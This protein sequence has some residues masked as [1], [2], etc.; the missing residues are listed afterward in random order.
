MDFLVHDTTLDI[1]AI[2]LCSIIYIT[3]SVAAIWAAFKY[4]RPLNFIPAYLVFVALNSII[5]NIQDPRLG[6]SYVNYGHKKPIGITMLLGPV[7]FFRLI[8]LTL[9]LKLRVGNLALL[10]IP[11][12]EWD[13]YES[14]G[15]RTYW[16][17]HFQLKAKER[18]EQIHR[19]LEGKEIPPKRHP[20]KRLWRI[21]NTRIEIV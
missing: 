17:E 2:L 11:V 7:G 16:A 14:A 12:H 3:G 19:Y 20:F 4:L 6:L 5:L 1:I 18:R 9:F 10:N 21:L 15:Y 8:A 13:K